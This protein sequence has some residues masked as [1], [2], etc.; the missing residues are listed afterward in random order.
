MQQLN[1]AHTYMRH[2]YV[3]ITVKVLVKAEWYNTIR[4]WWRNLPF[5]HGT[6]TCY[7]ASIVCG[8]ITRCEKRSNKFGTDCPYNF[9]IFLCKCAPNNFDSSAIRHFIATW[10]APRKPV[11]TVNCILLCCQS[12]TRHTFRGVVNFRSSLFGALCYV[13]HIIFNVIPLSTCA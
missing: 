7:I 11:L 13:A 10:Q 3:T 5:L 4:I 8:E 1:W 2:N 9:P 6:A 12:P